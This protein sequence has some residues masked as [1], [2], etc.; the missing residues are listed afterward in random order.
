MYYTKDLLTNLAYIERV[1]SREDRKDSDKADLEILD[2]GKFTYG[3]AHSL[4]TTLEHMLDLK[5]SQ[6]DQET[7]LTST[8]DDFGV[9]AYVECLQHLNANLIVKL[10]DA[11]TSSDEFI[12][13]YTWRP[14]YTV[15]TVPFHVVL[16]NSSAKGAPSRIKSPSADSF[17]IKRASMYKP[18]ELSVHVDNQPY[19]TITLP[20]FPAKTLEKQLRKV[21]ETHEVYGGGNSYPKTM[22]ITLPNDEQDAVIVPRSLD[23]KLDADIQ[24]RARLIETGARTYMDREACANINWHLDAKDGHVRGT[25][26]VSAVV[27]KA[28][29]VKNA[30]VAVEVIG[31]TKMFEGQ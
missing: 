30:E 21:A 22:C 25:A 16:L 19:P 29:P 7:L 13:E 8:L 17:P 28:V 2:Y 23:V 26:T 5:W 31:K 6:R 1:A 20:A 10:S 18:V 11:A 15:N 9:R 3:E 24:E 4:T 14:S 27:L 12:L